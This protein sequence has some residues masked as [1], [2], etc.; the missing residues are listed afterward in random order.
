MA[1]E[2]FNKRNAKIVCTIGPATSSRLKLQELIEAGMN[3]ARLNFSHGDYQ[4]HQSVINQVRQLSQ[5]TDEPIAILQ[6]LAGP[7]V[8][9]GRIDG[10]SVHLE[11]GERFTLTT[12]E[13][14]GNKSTVSVSYSQLPQ[15]VKT[16]DN[17]MLADGTIVLEVEEVEETEIHCRIA[18][19]GQL[20]S[21]K[22]VN[23]PSGL[24]GLPILGGKDLEDLQFGVD[25]GVDYLALSFVRNAADI[26]TAKDQLAR[27]GASGIPVIAKIETQAALNNFDEI[28]H[29]ADGIM[30][31]RGDLSIETPFTK[32][33]IL[34]KQLITKANHAAKPVI[35]ATQMLW[36][37]V[38]NPFPTRA[39]TA[40]VANA[41]MDGSDAVMLSDETTVGDYPVNAVKT[42]DAIVRDSE[43]SG[44]QIGWQ[45]SRTVSEDTPQASDEEVARAACQLA[46]RLGTDFISTVTR[47]GRTARLAAKYRPAQPILAATPNRVTY[48][49]LALIR[50]VVPI[51][52][53]EDSSSYEELVLKA[54]DLAREAGLKGKE[55]VFV[56]KNLVRYG[57]L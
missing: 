9:V 29:E 11:A 32:V 14:E 40:D 48:R 47:S 21:R 51:L 10:G 4:G 43:K 6:D 42:M 41:V 24:Y 19:G 2:V 26:L 52:I 7:K 17:L 16:G 45:H 31:A 28:L 44:L 25:Q 34:Q 53:P 30:I 39:E 35:T 5:E 18:Y 27:T 57:R 46:E 1:L 3:V 20:S 22:G 50:G 37:M 36:S 12:H 15:E 33:P 54:R 8:R 38:K 56:S 49:R 13:I 55:G 23:S